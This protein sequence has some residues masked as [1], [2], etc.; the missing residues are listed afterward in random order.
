VPAAKSPAV[1]N[2]M[3]LVMM[4]KLDIASEI[5]IQILCG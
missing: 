2:A 4:A 1:T 3:S 5:F